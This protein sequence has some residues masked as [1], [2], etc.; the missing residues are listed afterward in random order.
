MKAY[1]I[2]LS[3]CNDIIIK[4]V[5]QETWEYLQSPLPEFGSARKITETPPK[6]VSDNIVGCYGNG[7]GTIDISCRNDRAIHIVWR[8]NGKETTF[9]RFKDLYKFIA[10]NDIQIEKEYQGALY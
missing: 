3:G 2:V 9:I 7:D 5:D 10:D 8:L 6:N 4:L 1:L